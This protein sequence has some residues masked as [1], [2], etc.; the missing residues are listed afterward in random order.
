MLNLV[1][2]TIGYGMGAAH[3]GQRLAYR[4]ALLMTQYAPPFELEEKGRPVRLLTWV[5]DA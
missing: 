4:A 1:T 3:R 2:H 5:H